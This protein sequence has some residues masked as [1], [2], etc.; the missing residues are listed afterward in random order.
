[1]VAGRSTLTHYDNEVVHI[2]M[3]NVWWG[4]ILNRTRSRGR[5][6]VTLNR[7]QCQRLSTV[8]V[9]RVGSLE[10]KE[11]RRVDR[12]P[13]A[14]C[15][16]GLFYVLTLM[17]MCARKGALSDARGPFGITQRSTNAIRQTRGGAGTSGA[18]WD[19]AGRDRTGRGRARQ[20]RARQQ[21]TAMCSWGKT[22][23]F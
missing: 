17:R 13:R 3:H 9:T 20:W 14:S 7:E 5:G 6:H 10:I 12:F 2:I 11:I 23:S 4:F 15:V 18:T 22:H 19:K 1:M 21:E 8:W 16:L